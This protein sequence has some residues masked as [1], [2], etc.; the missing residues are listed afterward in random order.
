[1]DATFEQPEIEPT[2]TAQKRWFTS[3]L[4]N[5]LG[6]SGDFAAALP[7]RSSATSNEGSRALLRELTGLPAQPGIEPSAAFLQRVD[8]L[9]SALTDLV[10]TRVDALHLV[11]E[12]ASVQPEIRRNGTISCGGATCL[13]PT[14][15]GF[16]ALS[17]SR[18]SDF[19]ALPAFL[20]R[21]IDFPVDEQDAVW[22]LVSE[23]FLLEPSAHWVERATL[24]GMALGAL[25]EVATP[26]TE[27]SA[28]HVIDVVTADGATWAE[29]SKRQPVVID[30]S[31]LWAGPLCGRLLTQSGA[32]VVKVE[33]VS[34]PDG[35]RVGSPV[36]FDRLHQSQEFVLLD[37]SS[38]RGQKD[39]G[40]LITSADVVIEASRP[41][42]LE[43][44]GINAIEMLAAGPVRCWVSIT[45]F[46]RSG[47]N[48]NRVSFGDDAAVAGG[49]VAR[50]GQQRPV[51]LGDAIADPLTGMVAAFAALR[52][53]ETN[54][55]YLLAVAMTRVAAAFREPNHPLSFGR[56]FPL[57]EGK[58]PPKASASHLREG[59]KLRRM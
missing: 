33:D 48:A 47:S 30:L 31:S 23:R 11:T 36:M 28:V 53:L 20:E 25:G 42:A 21:V 49:L 35:M 27:S 4:E 16:V 59:A 44:M 38:K 58:I 2:G 43:A 19:H 26:T 41:R 52:A 24:L 5:S 32:R 57:S 29:R 51:F 54:R 39:L 8:W 15:D 46:G 55:K 13:L 1:M 18:P 14:S 3:L 12:R 17:L 37:L 9:G 34:R 40:A 10:G 7:T 56:D 45:G 6:L 50:V 22:R